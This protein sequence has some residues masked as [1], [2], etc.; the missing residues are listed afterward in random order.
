MPKVI[1]PLRDPGIYS[2]VVAFLVG[3][4]VFLFAPESDAEKKFAGEK[5]CDYIVI[6]A[7]D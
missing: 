2:M 1:F 5:L 7:E 4:L 6:E 3:I